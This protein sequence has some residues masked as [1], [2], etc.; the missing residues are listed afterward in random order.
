V[1]TESTVIPDELLR[2]IIGVGQVDLLVGL[3]TRGHAGTIGAVVRAVRS[4]VSTFYPRLRV[5]VLHLDRASSDGTLP[6]AL[7]VWE[8]DSRAAGGRSLRTTHYVAATTDRESDGELVRVMLAAADLLQ[9]R[10]V[11]V[12]DTDGEPAAE[13]IAA[14]AGPVWAQE[15]DVVAPVYARGA[16]DGL[17]VTQFVRPVTWAVYARRLSEPLVPA[18]ACSG[19]FAAHCTTTAW[20]TNPEQRLTRYWIVA[21]ALSGSFEVRQRALG[22]RTS[23]AGRPQPT[24]QDVFAPIVVSMFSCIEAHSEIWLARSEAEDLPLD[25]SIPAI[26]ETGVPEQA[27]RLL[28]SFAQDVDNLGEILGQILGADTMAAIRTASRDGAG[29]DYPDTLWAATVADFLVAFHRGVMRRD[30]VAQALMPL[31]RARAG[32]F[33]QRHGGAPGTTVDAAVEALAA[34]FERTRLQIV[35]QWTHQEEVEHG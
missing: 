10:A 15:A 34:W 27:P 25:G 16:A 20:S 28:E 26:D 32:A 18:F 24:L 21:E 6:A 12:V 17:L 11:V 22:R 8:E 33:L 9:A 13:E 23:Q 7:Q 4:C 31:Y 1:L 19:R 3:P 2:Q 14:L 35:R 5:A 30:H 29:A